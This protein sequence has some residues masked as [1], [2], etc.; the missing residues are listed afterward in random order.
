MPFDHHFFCGGGCE[1]GGGDVRLVAIANYAD[2]VVPNVRCGGG[3]AAIGDG[4]VAV[5]GLEALV[6]IF[7][8]DNLASAS[9]SLEESLLEE[10]VRCLR[11]LSL[12]EPQE[13]AICSRVVSFKFWVIL[14]NFVKQTRSIEICASASAD[15]LSVSLFV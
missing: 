9:S 2:A 8:S 7:L 10:G 6:A 14:S 15:G 13:I 1:Y 5:I 3:G 11:H 4:H 12:F